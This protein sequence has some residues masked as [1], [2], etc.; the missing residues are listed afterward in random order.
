MNILKVIKNP[1][2]YFNYISKRLKPYKVDVRGKSF[3]VKYRPF[4]K[5]VKEGKWEV[6]TFEI[7]EKFLSPNSPYIDIGAWLGPTTLY[8]CQLAR[9]CHAIEPDPQSF[10]QLRYNVG[11]NPNLKSKI[12][13]YNHCLSDKNEKIKFGNRTSFGNSTSSILFGDH[14]ASI[15]IDSFTLEEFFKKNEITDYNFIKM[16]IEGGESLVIPQAKDFLEKEKP[17]I[18]LSLHPHFFNNCEKDCEEII[19]SLSFYKNIFDNK[20]QKLNQEDL[21]AELV[22]ERV[23]K[24]LVFTDKE[25]N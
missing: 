5:N 8:G 14:K 10:K 16:D 13:I 20:G 7:F 6:E 25:W 9:H 11:V 1:G 24:D 19:K 22:S 12:T 2:F 21:L 18:H 3:F 23:G 15:L 17:T 4:W